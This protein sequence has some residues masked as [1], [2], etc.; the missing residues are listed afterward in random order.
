MKS[1]Q[2]KKNSVNKEVDISADNKVFVKMTHVKLYCIEHIFA[3]RTL[4]SKAT[5]D[6]IHDSKPHKNFVQG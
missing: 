1:E 5:Y 6:R 4:L 2:F 3:V